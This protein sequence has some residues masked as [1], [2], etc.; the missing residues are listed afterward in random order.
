M[1]H[2]PHADRSHHRKVLIAAVAALL[3]GAMLD[4][5]AQ[6][7]IRLPCLPSFTLP[8]VCPVRRFLGTPCPTC[9]ITRSVAHLL[10]CRP[11]ESFAAHR[12]G[13]LVLA[14]VMLQLPYRTWRLAGRRGLPDNLRLTKLALAGFLLLLVLNWLLPQVELP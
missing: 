10:H 8:V 2:S 7:A 4:V 13:W 14:G 12:L 9:G 5:D 3:A 11:A 1:K 6:Q